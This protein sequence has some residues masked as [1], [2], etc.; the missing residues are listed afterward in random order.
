MLGVRAEDSR[1]IVLRRILAVVV[2]IAFVGYA[3]DWTIEVFRAITGQVEGPAFQVALKGALATAALVLGAW[4]WGSSKADYQ[5]V[6]IITRPKE[7]LGFYEYFVQ[8]RAFFKEFY[9]GRE[10]RLFEK[11][12][13][14]ISRGENPSGWVLSRPS[15]QDRGLEI[16][17]LENSNFIRWGTDLYYFPNAK[18]REDWLAYHW[19][20]YE[21]SGT[22]DE[23]MMGR[24]VLEICGT[25]F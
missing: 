17:P 7:E 6:V 12:L 15:E 20:S 5:R 25:S 19:K 1:L 14:N 8:K 23:T 10:A 3:I 22:N 11:A 9:E 16:A 24:P 21:L 4:L 2:L 13:L 18:V